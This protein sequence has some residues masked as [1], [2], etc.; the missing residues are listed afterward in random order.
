MLCIASALVSTWVSK[1]LLP[2]H[3]PPPN[4]A[5][6]TSAPAAVLKYIHKQLT[7]GH[8]SGPYT[9]NSLESL[10]GPFCTSPLGVIPKSNGS[11]CIIQDLSAGNRHHPLVKSKITSDDFRTKWG[12]H[13]KVVPIVLEAPPRSL[14]ATMDVD[15]VFCQCPVRPDQQNHFVVMWDNAFYLNHCVAFSSASTCGVFGHLANA[16][17]AICHAHSMSPCTK[18]V[19]NFLFIAHLL[20]SPSQPCY[21]IN[22]L[23]ALGTWLGW[24]WKPLKT[25][26]FDNIF[27]Y[28]GFQWLLLQHTIEVPAAKKAKYL[29]CLASWTASGTQVSCHRA[30]TVL[31]TLVHSVLAVPDRHLQL[32]VLMCMVS[33]FNGVWN[34]FAQWTQPH[35]S[36]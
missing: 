30:E 11:E 19:D 5:F 13:K 1:L 15:A 22:N 34:R 20:P 17:V 8:Y 35:G 29:A 23:V 36:Q 7:L 26:L 31:S 6:A 21:S 18:W 2:P 3:T 33:A 32:V 24:L 28:L 12:N 16:F 14:A 10:I 25:L 9:R 4:H 27:T